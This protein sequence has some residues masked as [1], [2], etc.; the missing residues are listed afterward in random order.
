MNENGSKWARAGLVAG[1]VAS[2]TGNV[3]N[4]C[5]TETDVPLALRVPMAVIWPAFLFLA[6]E[7][8]VRNRGARGV[9]A[10][11]GQFGLL[12][13]TVPTAITSFLNLHAL[14]AK[15]SEPGMAQLTGPLAI[16]G[17]MLGCTIM[18]LAAR[19]H[20]VIPAMDMEPPATGQMATPEPVAMATDPFVAWESELDTLDLDMAS[21]TQPARPVSAP[22][23][24]AR[25]N[26]VRPDSI[27]ATAVAML[28]A[29]KAASPEERPRPGDRDILVGAAHGR[30][31]R[32]A[33]RWY[34]ALTAA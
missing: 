3:A 17:L 12:T 7:V 11:I 6:V 15:A 24:L 13:I 16:D 20:A 14:M 26:E 28:E 9:L 5:L 1:V 4:A 21:A 23:A 18:M 33:R 29:W 10:R 25:S 19:V 32:A 27:P 8:L 34:A 2:V 30:S 22:P 31:P